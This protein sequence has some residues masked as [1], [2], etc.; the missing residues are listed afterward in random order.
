MPF[1]LI[2]KLTEWHTNTMPTMDKKLID[3]NRITYILI[4]GE[5]APEAEDFGHGV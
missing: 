2:P 4:F 1:F 3:A 5:M